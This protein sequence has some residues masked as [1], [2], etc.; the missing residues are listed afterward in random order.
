MVITVNGGK[1]SL[2]A[3]LEVFGSGTVI[4]NNGYRK[5]KRESDIYIYEDLKEVRRKL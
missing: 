1:Q 5:S 2:L 4:F 3:D